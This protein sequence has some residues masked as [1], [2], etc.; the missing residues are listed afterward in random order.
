M[1]WLELAINKIFSVLAF[2]SVTGRAFQVQYPAIT[3]HAI[4]RADS[5]PSIY[6]QL[7]DTFGAANGVATA[8]QEEGEEADVP[9]SELIIVP[10][11][12]TARKPLIILRYQCF[13]ITVFS[14]AYL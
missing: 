12:G 14:R 13:L 8:G 7:D 4:S 11:D 3:L 1:A 10:S 6:C 5:G 2:V 9:M